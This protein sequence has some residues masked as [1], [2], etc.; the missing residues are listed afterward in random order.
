MYMPSWKVG[1]YSASISRFPIV[2]GFARF[3]EKNF[4]H[5][6]RNMWLAFLLKKRYLN[7]F[8]KKDSGQV[9]G[10]K[11]KRGTLC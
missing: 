4:S 2:D 5:N 10:Y 7:A 8:K 6:N 11:V 3:D 1:G 9:T